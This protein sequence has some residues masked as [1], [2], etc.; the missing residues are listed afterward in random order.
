MLTLLTLAL[1]SAAHAATLDVTGGVLRFVAATDG[2]NNVSFTQG[3]GTVTVTRETAALDDDPLVL[4]AGCTG[5]ATAATCTGASRLEIDL[6]D[7]ADRMTATAITL[8]ITASG[9]DSNDAIDTGSGN[10]TLDGGAGDDDLDA[11]SGNDVLRGGDGNDTLAPNTGTDGVSGGDGIDT[12]TYGLRV[13]P[14]FTLDGVAN[15]GSAGE[16]DLIGVDVEN[17]EGAASS[18]VVTLVGDGRGNHLEVLAGPGVI[19]G[20]EGADVLEGGPGND[21]INARDSSPD[22]VICAGGTDSVLAD[23]L[24]LISPSCENVSVQASPGGPFDDRP[25]LLAWT[26]PT[27]AATLSAN[28]PTILRVDASDDRGVAK[29]QFLDDDRLVCEDAAAPYECAYEPR[30]GDVGRNTLVAIAVDGAGQTTSLVRPV[31]VRRFTSPGFS[32]TLRPSR[33]R[34]APYSFRATGTLRRP[35]AVAPSQGCSGRVVITAKRGK[36][37]V[38]TTRTS[39]TRNCEYAV[40]VRFRSKVGSRIRLT[41]KFDGNDVLSSRSA[42]SRTV[43]LG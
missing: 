20:G 18:G 29:V 14:S 34:T 35:G 28:D 37:T 16:N 25:P 4:G 43:R 33:D 6:A 7:R 15:D 22:T 5:S 1:P 12:V 40:T 27:V 3:A 36:R 42:P 39:L 13:S 26:A 38:G 9:G 41:A 30:G 8:P 10:D 24:D 32:L 2:V 21:M 23:T 31:T 17:V 19:T 11:G